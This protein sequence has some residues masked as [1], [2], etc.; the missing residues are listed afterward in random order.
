MFLSGFAVEIAA[1]IFLADL[2]IAQ[3]ALRR[4]NTVNNKFLFKTL[5]L[6]ESLLPTLVS[7]GVT[8]LTSIILALVNAI[9]RDAIRTYF[10]VSLLLLQTGI[11]CYSAY[12]AKAKP[13]WKKALHIGGILLGVIGVLILLSALIPSFGAGTGMGTWTVLTAILLPLSPA[14]YIIFN[15][16][17]PFLHRTAK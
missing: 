15:L 5:L 13:E 11:L 14:L 3:S 7:V 2:P 17:L 8:A 4:P 1:L 12:R 6:G 9:P 16:L 10:F